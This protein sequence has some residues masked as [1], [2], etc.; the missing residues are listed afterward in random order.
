LNPL[1]STDRDK[2]EENLKDPA[3]FAYAIGFRLSFAGDDDDNR[4]QEFALTGRLPT[5]QYSNR[6]KYRALNNCATQ[7]TF[8]APLSSAGWGPYSTL[9]HL[10]LTVKSP[11]TTNVS[12]LIDL[13]I[14]KE[15]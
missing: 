2:E 12:T 1:R 5:V 14:T 13:G 8:E 7:P 6:A 15:S 3:I 4:G 11:M 9:C 10:Q